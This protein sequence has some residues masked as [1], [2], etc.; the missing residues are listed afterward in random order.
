MIFRA[1]VFPGFIFTVLLSFL[2]DWLDRKLIARFQGRVGPP[3]Y[4]S[5]ADFFKLL[6]K[7]D[8]TPI[9]TSKW[10]AA[11]LPLMAFASVSTAAV[12]IPVASSSMPGFQGDFI[13][14][15]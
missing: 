6:G 13:V 1:F 12:S 3:W 14:V 2:F 8:I 4:Q 15:M 10:V 11:A 9:N 5:I 7:E